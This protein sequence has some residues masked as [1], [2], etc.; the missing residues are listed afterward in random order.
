[1]FENFHVNLRKNKG[2]LT[3]IP[4][5]PIPEYGQSRS[6]ELTLSAFFFKKL[7]EATE[8]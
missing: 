6:I 7:I 4:Y 8:L 5:I 3:H 2:F 1:M